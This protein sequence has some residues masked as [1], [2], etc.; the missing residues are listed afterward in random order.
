LYR[1]EGTLSARTPITRVCRFATSQCNT[2]WLRRRYSQD[3]PGE[4]RRRWPRKGEEE[5][6]LTKIQV[7]ISARASWLT[8]NGCV[9]IASACMPGKITAYC[10]LTPSRRI[11]RVTM[12]PSFDNAS[13]GES[14]S[15]LP[16]NNVL[17]RFLRI[18]RA[19]DFTASV[20]DTNFLALLI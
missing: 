18:F 8:L 5:G 2:T 1:L 14:I 13:R 19:G 12:P 10:G 4:D 7:A 16:N 9:I 11:I 15:H 20:F 3:G 6:K 17:S